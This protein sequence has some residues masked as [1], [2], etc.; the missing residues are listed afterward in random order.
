MTV[1]YDTRT[2]IWLKYS[3]DNQVTQSAH[4]D[5]P[6]AE[7][8]GTGD[9]SVGDADPDELAKHLTKLSELSAKLADEGMTSNRSTAD[10]TSANLDDPLEQYYHDAQQAF[11]LASA[12]GLAEA[13]AAK[14]ED[15]DASAGEKPE[16]PK[17]IGRSLF[18]ALN[19]VTWEEDE[20]AV[21][22]VGWAASWW[23]EKLPSES[24][25][26]EGRGEAKEEY[27]GEADDGDRF[28]RMTDHGHIVCV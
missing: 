6:N 14:A 5:E 13:L 12:G 7:P 9:V 20:N 23:Q 18:I 17:E 11:L 21:L 15:E 16:V 1:V 19:L 10:E 27:K 28:E 26:D 4:V 3:A 2:S 22:E 8:A 24:D 25:S